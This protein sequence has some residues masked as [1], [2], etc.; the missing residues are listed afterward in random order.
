MRSASMKDI[1]SPPAPETVVPA[2]SAG[3]TVQGVVVRGGLLAVA[4]AKFGKIG[5]TAGT[6][7]LSIWAYSFFY[8]WPF[9]LGFVLLISLHEMGHFLA[10]RQRGLKVGAPT[11]IPFFGAWVALK[12]TPMNAETEAYIGLAGPVAGTVASIACFG[13]GLALDSTLLIALS[14]SGLFLNLL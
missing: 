1:A 3:Q 9:A 11:F 4:L 10:A 2:P 6:M 5:L 7:V 12:D 8:G 13:L 14:Y